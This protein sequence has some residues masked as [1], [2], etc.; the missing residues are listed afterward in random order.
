M[1]DKHGGPKTCTFIIPLM[2]NEND[3]GLSHVLNC[4]LIVLEVVVWR[5]HGT[6]SF[7]I[8]VASSNMHIDTQL[9]SVIAPVNGSTLFC[10][11]HL[12]SFLL[13]V[14]M[15][16]FTVTEQVILAQEI[17]ENVVG[18]FSPRISRTTISVLL[19]GRTWLILRY[20]QVNTL[21]GWK[22]LFHLLIKHSCLL[23][24]AAYLSIL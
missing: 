5:E 8:C 18:D 4:R 14:E 23:N 16:M 20:R 7:E 10:F 24:I 9:Y 1:D 12:S 22:T 13:I 6:E 17:V 19:P 2:P 3:S 15:S 11:L 21:L